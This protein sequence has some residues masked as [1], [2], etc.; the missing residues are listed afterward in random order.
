MQKMQK[1]GKKYTQFFSFPGVEFLFLK[2]Q[3][4]QIDC[5]FSL[6]LIFGANN[7]LSNRKNKKIE[8]SFF[9]GDF[10]GEAVGKKIVHNFNFNPSYSSYM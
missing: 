10:W 1:V 7:F 5:I 2:V 4:Y 6:H 3:I 9:G 8:F